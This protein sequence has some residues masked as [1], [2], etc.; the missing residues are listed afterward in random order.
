[1]SKTGSLINSSDFHRNGGSSK[2]NLMGEFHAGIP[3]GAR[4]VCEHLQS[5]T[6]TLTGLKWFFMCT[7]GLKNDCKET[8]TGLKKGRV[9][10]TSN[11]LS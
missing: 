6:E 8:K 7:Q 5:W 10:H 2:W 1:M 3:L 9:D 11:C 4:C